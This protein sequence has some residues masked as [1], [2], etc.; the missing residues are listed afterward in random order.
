MATWTTADVVNNN[1]TANTIADVTGL[2]FAVSAGVR[3]WFR[4]VI[5][6]TA[7][8][9]TTGSRWSI[10]GPANTLLF[11]RSTYTLTATTETLNAAVTGYNLPATCNATSVAAGNVAF[12]EGVVQPSVDGTVIARFASEVTLSAITAKA[13]AMVDYQAL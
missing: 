11:Y 5:P 8:A 9:T 2:S 10:N 6:Y 7:A 13:G 4:F 3:Y 1:V 12:I